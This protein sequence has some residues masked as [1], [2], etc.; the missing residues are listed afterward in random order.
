[1]LSQVVENFGLPFRS[2]IRQVAHARQQKGLR[3][4]MIQYTQFTRHID[5]CGEI[6]GQMKTS[7]GC[8]RITV[9]AAH[10]ASDDNIQIAD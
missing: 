1:M 5:R 2:P 9:R 4:G 8:P 6:I 10:G 7:R 3:P